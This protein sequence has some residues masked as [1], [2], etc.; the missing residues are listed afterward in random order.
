MTGMARSVTAL[1]RSRPEDGSPGPCPPDPGWGFSLFLALRR[2]SRGAWV[3]R[4]VLPPGRI[5]R[6]IA[7]SVPSGR[8]LAC[9]RELTTLGALE[10]RASP[11]TTKSGSITTR[12]DVR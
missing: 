7:L 11:R 9:R 3:F 4:M 6:A 8:D 12:G 5:K 10:R 2:P 1:L